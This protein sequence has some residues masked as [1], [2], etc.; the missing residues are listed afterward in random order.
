MQLSTNPAIQI[1][2]KG[3]SM[4]QLHFAGRCV[5]F[6]VSYRSAGF[7]ADRLNHLLSSLQQHGRKG[8]VDATT[9]LSFG[10]DAL[11]FSGCY[12]TGLASEAWIVE[13]GD[14]TPIRSFPSR[15]LAESFRDALDEYDRML[16]PSG[17]NGEWSDAQIEWF[18]NHPAPIASACGGSFQIRKQ[19]VH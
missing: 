10:S 12:V 15:K 6:A 11:E 17:E 4:I 2:V 18:R 8:A 13:A 5:G 1:Y 7:E 9:G 3:S 19:G 14:G 16:P